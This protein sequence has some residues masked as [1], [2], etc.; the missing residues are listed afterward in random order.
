MAKTNAYDVITDRV[1]KLLEAGTVPWRRTWVAADA[2]NLVSG[3][4]YRGI[5][6]FLLPCA[7]YT[8]PYWLTF[9]QAK[10]LGGHVRKGEQGCPVV[11][12]NWV[13]RENAES[14]E[15]ERIP[16][17]RY[18]TS[19]NLE[20][21]DGIPAEK[22]P[23]AEAFQPRSDAS[24]IDSCERVVAGMQHPPTIQHEGQRP[25][26]HPPLD[27]VS[28]PATQWFESDQAYYA[29]LFHELTHATGHANRLNRPG[30][31]DQSAAFGTE[32]YSKEEL[33]AEMGAAFLCGHTGIENRTIDNSASYVAGWLRKLKNDSKLVVQ[34]A[35]QAQKA[36]DHILG[37]KWDDAD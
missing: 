21:C 3:K 29:T 4:C 6:A 25:S 30:I 18:Y 32:T 31:T 2:R 7:G 14:G 5:N 23:A 11:F 17:V 34:A 15:A 16:F 12:W 26:Y 28:I 22:I 35:A 10:A 8:S 9:K 19:F 33:V 13:D 24:P 37:R 20:Q 1:V 27:R 36:T